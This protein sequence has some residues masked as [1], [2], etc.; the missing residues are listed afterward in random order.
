[1]TTRAWPLRVR[2]IGLDWLGPNVSPVYTHINRVSANVFLPP[3]LSM[4][5]VCMPSP[6]LRVKRLESFDSYNFVLHYEVAFFVCP[7]LQRKRKKKNSF[8]GEFAEGT[9]N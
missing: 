7:A 6:C 8:R 4:W 1:M 5:R 2:T 3:R 9:L